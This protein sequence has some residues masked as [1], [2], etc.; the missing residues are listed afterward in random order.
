MPATNVDDPFSPLPPG[1][2]TL[3][4]EQVRNSQRYRLSLAAMQACRETGYSALTIGHIT[5][6]ARVSR[7]TFYAFYR[8]KLECVAAACD[9]ALDELTNDVVRPAVGAG[10]SWEHTVDLAVAHYLHS[11]RDNP[12]A[13]HFVVVEAFEIPQLSSRRRALLD[14]FVHSLTAMHDEARQAGADL[15]DVPQQ[16]FEILVSGLDDLVRRHVRDKGVDNITELA[17]FIERATKAICQG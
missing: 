4:T 5:S 10:T 6:R 8:N 13:T 14:L 3:T 15:P 16:M 12:A 2:H 17:P 7:R 1:R 11:L 9:F